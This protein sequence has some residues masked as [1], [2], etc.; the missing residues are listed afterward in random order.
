V[1]NQVVV[2]RKGGVIQMYDGNSYQLVREWKAVTKDVGDP[3]IGLD[4]VDGK[5]CSCSVKGKVLIGDLTKDD[6]N[7]KYCYMVG[8]SGKWI[9]IY[10]EM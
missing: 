3:I 8:R 10:N 1:V 6:D 4:F 7:S 9:L 5:L 2:A